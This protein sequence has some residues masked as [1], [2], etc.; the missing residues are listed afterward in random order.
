[1]SDVLDDLG[2]DANAVYSVNGVMPTNHALTLE[3]ADVF[4]AEAAD[5]QTMQSQLASLST[6]VGTATSQVTSLSTT[7]GTTLSTSATALS[8]AQS[9]QL[10]ALQNATTISTL[11]SSLSTAASTVSNSGTL[12]TSISTT[13]SSSISNLGSTLSSLSTGVGGNYSHIASNSVAINSLSTAINRQAAQ[14]QIITNFLGGVQTSLSTAVS[15]LSNLFST[16][17]DSISTLTVNGAV[18]VTV[19][20]PSLDSAAGTIDLAGDGKLGFNTDNEN[21]AI[22]VKDKI[23]FFDGTPTNISAKQEADPNNLIKFGDF[24]TNAMSVSNN[25]VSLVPDGVSTFIDPNTTY[26]TTP[27]YFHIITKRTV[28]TG[29]GTSNGGATTPFA[30]T[31]ADGTHFS[32]IQQ[33]GTVG[34]IVWIGITIPHFGLRPSLDQYH[35]KV[36]LDNWYRI[37]IWNTGTGF[38]PNLVAQGLP[39]Q[40]NIYPGTFSQ[41]SGP[42]TIVLPETYKSSV[43]TFDLVAVNV[44]GYVVNWNLVYTS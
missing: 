41:W 36:V 28:R 19:G 21:L 23:V 11:Q 8:T 15:D 5:L 25:Q 18:N 16:S 22:F 6:M 40:T 17:G 2:T 12:L 44:T 7:V 10:Q 4:A 14:T 43:F 39:I 3:P 20:T 32:F 1:M 37:G 34:G 27:K 33:N 26:T 9:A 29:D 35:I 31:A 38:G 13:F 30:V 24:T 42:N